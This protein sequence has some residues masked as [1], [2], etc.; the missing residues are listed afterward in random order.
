LK[1]R[2]SLTQMPQFGGTSSGDRR[3][4][5][6]SRSFLLEGFVLRF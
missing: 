1:K 5:I 3:L 2:L 6:D 4:G